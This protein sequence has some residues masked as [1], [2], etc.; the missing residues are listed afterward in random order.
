LTSLHLVPDFLL[1]IFLFRL[2]F[3]QFFPAFLLLILQK[4]RR[5]LPGWPDSWSADRVVWG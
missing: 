2:P 4:W 3:P 5:V 1:G